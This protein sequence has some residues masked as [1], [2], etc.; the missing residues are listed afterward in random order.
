MAKNPKINHTV[1]NLLKEKASKSDCTYRVAAIGFDKK[2]NILGHAVNKHSKWNVLEK[3]DGV[4]RSGTAIHAER[5]L[6]ERYQG[7]IKTILICRVGKRGALRP[8]DACPTCQ[9]VADKLGVKIISI[10]SKND[11]L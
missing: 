10:C 5:R 1:V 11:E 4:G 6:M 9:K 3:E 8:I 2:G 7:V